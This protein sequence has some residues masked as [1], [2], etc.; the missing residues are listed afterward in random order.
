MGEPSALYPWRW[1]IAP[2]IP[3]VSAGIVTD[4]DIAVCAGQLGR[5]L[6]ALHQEAPIEAPSNPFRGGPLSDRDEVTRR[7]IAAVRERSERARLMELWAGSLAAERYGRPPVWLH[8][9]LHP[10][11]LL[12]V[13]GQVSGVIDFGD[14]TAGDPATDL[15][16][17]W[18]LVATD[19][20][21]FWAEYGSDDTPL[22]LR[23]RGWA[24][25]LGLAY[26]SNSADNP[27]MEQIG[28][29]TLRAVLELS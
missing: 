10:G 8:G 15:A 23:G 18:N 29:Q 13:D 6:K 27:M 9:D 3:G 17:A 28:E 24:I 26:L 1:L 5:F 21:T 12:V 19:Q 4:L 20:E 25:A 22:R 2:H 7:R 16:V 14:I 11:N